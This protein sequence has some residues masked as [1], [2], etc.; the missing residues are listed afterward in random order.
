MGKDNFAL[1]KQ[2][3]T[4]EKYLYSFD[5]S[6]TMDVSRALHKIGLN[7]GETKVYL[8]LLKLGSVPVSKLKEETH[9]HR[10]TIYD[11]VEKLLNKGLVTYVVKTGVKYYN[12]VN[13]EKLLEYVKEK[14]ET[15]LD[16]LPQLLKF[17]S[18][19][20]EEIHV[21]VYKGTEGVKSLLNDV[22][23][24]G[25]DYVIFGID[26]SIFQ[27]RFGTLM[28]KF[29]RKEKEKGFKERILTSEEVTYIYP[30]E[31]A[32][33]RYLPKESF[34]PTPTYVY[35]DTVSILIWEPLNVIKIRNAAL[36]DSYV[37]HFEILWKLSKTRPIKTKP[38]P[39]SKPKK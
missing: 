13:P 38:T 14:E 4:P 18:L 24:V 9:L 12:A 31:T 6:F 11:F 2:Q 5:H 30:Y 27:Q 10:T 35:G 25:K 29:F 36:A 22:L 28:D 26:E 8:A 34:N 21:E 32:T 7:T 20:P 23:R 19:Q 17:S 3:V 15:V 1:N 39:S 33:Y 16:V 37:K